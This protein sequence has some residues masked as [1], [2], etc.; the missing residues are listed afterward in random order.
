[1][2]AH[3]SL[4]TSA[5]QCTIFLPEFKKIY[6]KKSRCYVYIGYIYGKQIILAFINFINAIQKLWMV[7][8]LFIYIYIY[9]YNIYIYIY[10]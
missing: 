10:I 7:N 5:I 8:K 9:T 3:F 1:M 6:V 4:M 2:I